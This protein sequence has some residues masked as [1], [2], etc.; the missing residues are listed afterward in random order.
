MNQVKINQDW[1]ITQG[2]SPISWLNIYA[3]R[4]NIPEVPG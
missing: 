4:A 3:K 1:S 2:T